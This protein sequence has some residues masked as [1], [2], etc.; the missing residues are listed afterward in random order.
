LFEHACCCQDEDGM[1]KDDREHNGWDG[2]ERMCRTASALFGVT[3]PCLAVNTGQ[4]SHRFA[5]GML[6]NGPWISKPEV[7]AF[8]RMDMRWCNATTQR[9]NEVTLSTSGSI[10]RLTS[11]SSITICVIGRQNLP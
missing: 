2:M 11:S 5:E 1:R 6:A 7:H 10:S 8:Q 4:T 3:S 9:E